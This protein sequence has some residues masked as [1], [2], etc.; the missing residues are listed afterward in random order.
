M[1]PYLSLYHHRRLRNRNLKITCQNPFGASFT[2]AKFLTILLHRAF[3][4]L[5]SDSCI[6]VFALFAPKQRS[7][8][9]VT[10]NICTVKL[11]MQ[12]SSFSLGT[13]VQSVFNTH[14][15]LMMMMRRSILQEI[16]SKFNLLFSSAEA[17]FNSNT[18][19]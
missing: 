11:T 17:C 7:F 1:M 9:L 5:L 13:L 18:L 2:P 12:L 6:T 8:F 19:H 10:N 14:G 3:Y 16:A 15:N 4:L